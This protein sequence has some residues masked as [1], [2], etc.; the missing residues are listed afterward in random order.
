MR[1]P[2]FHFF[3]YLLLILVLSSIPGNSVP[4][5]VSLTWD[6]LIHFFEYAILGFLGY[7][8]F[9]HTNEL[10]VYLFCIIGILFGCFDELW[11]SMIP[12]RFSS[13]YDIIADGIG[14]IFGTFASNYF[15]KKYL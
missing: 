7:R 2:K 4:S 11:Q 15:Y 14:V 10:N 6:K 5:I 9:L 1:N 8:A 13:H 3:L 12:G